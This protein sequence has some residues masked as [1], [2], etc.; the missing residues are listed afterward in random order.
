MSDEF[1]HVGGVVI[2]RNGATEP[3]RFDKILE[4]IDG[5]ATGLSRAVDSSAVT[6]R[7]ISGFA[8]GM[9]TRELDV[10]AAQICAA[11]TTRHPDYG[12]LAARILAS[13]L[14]KSTPSTFSAAIAALHTLFNARTR[15]ATPMIADDVAAFV[16][17]NAERLDAAIRDERDMAFDY[18]GFKTLERSYLLRDTNG[19]VVERPQYMW[20]RTAVGIH[21][22]DIDAV[23]ETYD[24]MSLGLFTHASPTLFNAGTRNPQLS[25]CFLLQIRKDSIEGIYDTLKDCA[26]I[27]K[28]GGGIGVALHRVRARGSYIAGTNGTSNGL[29]PMLSVYNT[30]ASY[31]DQ[32]G[33]KRK[34]AFATY[35]E[36]WHADIFDFISMRRHG[37]NDKARAR[38]LFCGLWIPD[39]FMERVEKFGTWSLM[40]PA[41]CPG[42]DECYGDKFRELY[43]SYEAEG[44]AR[45]VIPARQLWDEILIAQMETGAPYM[46]YKDHANRKSN[47][48]HLGTIQCSNLCTEIIEYTAPDETAVC[49]LASISLPRFV[50]VEAQTFDFARLVEVIGVITRNLD[51]VIDR[52]HYPIESARRSNL[53]HR[54]LGMGVQGLA[55]AFA[56]LDLPFD[57]PGAEALNVQIF[58]TIYYA[59]LVAS[60][61]LAE[62]H[63]PYESYPG[64]PVSKGQLQFDMWGVAPSDRH[65]W[66]ALRARIAE[67][68]VRNSLLVAPMP[69]AS[70][71]QILGNT[72]CFE[73]FQSMIFTRTVLAGEFTV[74]NTHL[75]NRLSQLGL[76]NEA[77]KNKILQ[78]GGSIQSIE[79]IPAHVRNVFRTVWE[80]KQR[81]IINMAA[82]RAPF[83]DQSQS[84]N[85]HLEETSIEKLTA[86]HLYA[87]KLG[88]K[89]GMYYL[90]AKPAA[91]AMRPALPAAPAAPAAPTQA[92]RDACSRDNPEACELCSS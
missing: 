16:A 51:R 36:P 22:G 33:G 1:G 68:G 72:E 34:G 86:M 60:C 64:S 5:Q 40:C 77:L 85:I 4:R 10:H 41:E 30:T 6:Q 17:A 71:S 66:P 35:L 38:E 26:Q 65:D 87:W 50:N 70:T 88:L 67:H 32:G 21:L 31:V 61:E 3:V 80:I 62:R 25:S 48:Q 53:R 89:T 82:A 7:V 43:E 12:V 58:E 47:H 54:P 27:S 90:R 73:P 46:L 23:I 24:L 55:D 37:G 15:R 39:L 2:K 52:T 76:W 74:V 11:W 29:M 9:T 18:F 8:S 49:N 79:E 42:L 28:M 57:S 69:T 92:E 56:M 78:A 91:R 13:N 83:I 44:R 20:M 14:R 75:V 63:G 84:L 81:V 19:N 59:A 45:R